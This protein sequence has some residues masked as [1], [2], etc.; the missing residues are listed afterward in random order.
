MDF[1]RKELSILQQRVL[2]KRNFLQVIVGPRQ[3]GKTTLVKQL[4]HKIEL[5][6]ILESADSVDSLN[7][8]WIAQIWESAR[9][10]ITAQN[11]PEVLLIIDEIQKISNWSEQ[12]KK[13]WDEDSLHGTNIKVILLGSS[14]LLLQ[15]GLTESLAGR[16]ELLPLS[17]WTFSEMKEAFGWSASQYAWFGGYPGSVFLIQD[18]NRWKDYVRNSL[19]ETTISK[20]ILLLT[21][22]N[23]PALLKRLFE[24]GS[25]YSGQILSYTK[26]LGQLLDAGNTTT[27]SHY[28]DLLD[29]AGLLG[30]IEKYATNS[31][32][33]RASSP[34][35]QV[36]N[37]AIIAAQSDLHY[38]DIILQPK[39]WGRVIES[40]IGVHLINACKTSSMKLFYWREGNDEV[41]FVL[42][43]GEQLI[44]I[45]VKT[46]AKRSTQGMRKFNERFSPNKLL[47]VGSEG[48]PWEDFLSMEV[49]MLF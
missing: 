2:E 35:F 31:I 22:V 40:A 46:N 25:L 11:V 5:P 7:E 45:E 36:Y 38:Q 30:G 12:V 29:T 21:Q 9:L 13:L 4:M 10:K 32:H 42:T 20:D 34:K 37:S 47:L 14:R 15:K 27:L 43:K 3:V 8:T 26:M 39:E 49:E 1:E 6:T 18:E 41:D 17:H 24:L 16:F 28:L 48:I 23:K 33:K 19:L 44:G